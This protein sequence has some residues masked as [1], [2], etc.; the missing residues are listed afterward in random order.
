M[1]TRKNR[2]WR[3]ENRWIQ[4]TMCLCEKCGEAY[5]AGLE[6]VCG[7][8]NSYPQEGSGENDADGPGVA[9][10]SGLREHHAT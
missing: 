6:H 7:Q 3:A 10:P 1:R 2:L 5:E 8:V 9:A 4:A